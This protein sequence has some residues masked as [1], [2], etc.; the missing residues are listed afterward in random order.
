MKCLNCNGSGVVKFW[1]T[2]D[3]FVEE[4]CPH[5]NGTGKISSIEEFII[6][7]GILTGSRAMGFETSVSDWD[8]AIAENDYNFI[9]KYICSKEVIYGG[10]SNNLM[11]NERSV[12]FWLNNKQYNLIV[13]A[14]ENCLEIIKDITSAVSSFK[15]CQDKDTRHRMFEGLCQLLIT[16][17]IRNIPEI[18]IDDSEIP[19]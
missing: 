4:S 2:F 17:K 6:Q 19:F 10:S 12:K 14:N 8:Y 3:E 11:N 7:N 18:E 5:C 1:K 15:Q 9:M 13:Y 16:N